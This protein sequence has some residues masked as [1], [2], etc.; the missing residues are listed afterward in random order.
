MSADERTQRKADF[1]GVKR[2]LKDKID[3]FSIHLALTVGGHTTTLGYNGVA[4][5]LADYLAQFLGQCTETP[6]A[7]EEVIDRLCEYMKDRVSGRVPETE[8]PDLQIVN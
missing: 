3:A 4:G 5:V 1:D 2:L 8:R 7:A 6:A